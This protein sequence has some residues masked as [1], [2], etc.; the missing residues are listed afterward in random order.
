MPDRQRVEAFVALVE[1]ARFVE[2]LE[3]FYHPQATMQDN[4]QPPRAGLERLH[5]G[6]SDRRRF[7]DLETLLRENRGENMPVTYL[8]PRA[9]D[10]A[11][12]GLADMAVFEAGVANLTPD[13]QPGDLFG[14]SGTLKPG[15]SN[16][17]ISIDQQV[18]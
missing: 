12:G 8:R 10:G 13:P 11:M 17:R 2:A 6:T 9:I 18:P 1:A 15:A 5:P 7:V 14:R 4:Q 3:Q 16:I